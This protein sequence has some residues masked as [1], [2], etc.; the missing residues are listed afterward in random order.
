M[1][2]TQTEVTQRNHQRA[3]RFFWAFLISATTISQ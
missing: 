2:T 3:V 1:M